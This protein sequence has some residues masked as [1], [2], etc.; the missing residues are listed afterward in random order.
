MLI[1]DTLDKLAETTIPE[2]KHKY[3]HVNSREAWVEYVAVL[4]EQKKIKF[5]GATLQVLLYNWEQLLYQKFSA[6]N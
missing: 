5:N 2:G 6:L 1:Y 4:I 3:L